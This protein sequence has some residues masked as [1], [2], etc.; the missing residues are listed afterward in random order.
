M[1]DIRIH[2]KNYIQ[3][4]ELIMN[5]FFINDIVENARKIKNEVKLEIRKTLQE[6][7]TWYRLYENWEKSIKI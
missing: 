2:L 5:I 3:T 4:L 7:I 1:S 6:E